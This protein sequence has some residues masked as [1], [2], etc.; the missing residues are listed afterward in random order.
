MGQGFKQEDYDDFEKAC[1]VIKE[2]MQMAVDEVHVATEHYRNS[3][4]DPGGSVH[5]A[6]QS[7]PQSKTP[8]LCRFG[9]DILNDGLGEGLLHGP[10][11]EERIRALSALAEFMIHAKCI[12]A[13]DDT[14]VLEGNVKFG[15]NDLDVVLQQYLPTIPQ[16][17]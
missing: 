8:T 7:A 13:E 2:K 9:L 10:T 4:P 5:V 12:V 3:P 15:L 6:N 1:K 11:A 17:A 14:L 16:D